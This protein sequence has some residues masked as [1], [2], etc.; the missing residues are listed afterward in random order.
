MRA[1]ACLV[2]CTLLL[3][4][5]CIT[6]TC[7]QLVL[8]LRVH[9]CFCSDTNTCV[10]S[11]TSVAS[12]L[13]NRYTPLACVVSPWK[14][15]RIKCAARG[16]PTTRLS[17]G[18]LSSELGECQI[19]SEGPHCAGGRSAN[20]HSVFYYLFPRVDV[21]RYIELGPERGLEAF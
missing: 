6:H 3:L 20:A 12:S 15:C 4:L 19:F 1:A 18:C 16:L 5:L 2:Q 7:L 17:S 21:G 13:L 10:C 14:M 8:T 9:T 11:D